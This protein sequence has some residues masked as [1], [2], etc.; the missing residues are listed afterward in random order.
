SP[1]LKLMDERLFI[2]AAM[3]FVLPEAAH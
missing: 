2:D 3:G 1:E